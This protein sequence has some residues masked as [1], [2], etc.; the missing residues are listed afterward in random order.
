MLLA[1]GV[2]VTEVRFAFAP[3]TYQ[4]EMPRH[5]RLGVAQSPKQL[6]GASEILLPA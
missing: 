5:D 3:P 4:N 2:A 1:I 6:R